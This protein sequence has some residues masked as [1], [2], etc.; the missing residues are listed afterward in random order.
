MS[1]VDK[2][3]RATAKEIISLERKSYY[4]EDQPRDRLRKIREVLDKAYK[5][6]GAQ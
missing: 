3:V 4:G 6:R 5:E 1:D 2:K